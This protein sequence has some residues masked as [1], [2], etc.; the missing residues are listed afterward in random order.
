M[1]T[2]FIINDKRIADYFELV[3]RSLAT[4]ACA[5]GGRHDCGFPMEKINVGRSCEHPPQLGD[6]NRGRVS[7]I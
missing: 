6:Q 3:K 4:T 1:D 5:L 2:R 7:S